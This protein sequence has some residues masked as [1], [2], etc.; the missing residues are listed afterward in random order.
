MKTLT[1][2]IRLHKQRLDEKRVRL[3]EI[4]KE[5]DRLYGAIAD[6][7]AELE[8]EKQ[9]AAGS[10]DA[11]RTFAAYAAH[12]G[13]RR[14]A[15]ENEIIATGPRI[16]RAAEEVAEAFRELKKYEISRDLRQERENMLEARR[17]QALLDEMGSTI[18]RRG[19]AG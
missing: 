18:R 12:V 5:R 15:H 1:T 10:Y 9:T 19:G 8:S 3:T 14:R 17:E 2:L 11:A 4:E 7:A 6:L 13:D 16:A